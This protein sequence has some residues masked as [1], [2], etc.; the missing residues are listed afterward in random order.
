M[1][2]R[3]RYRNDIQRFVTVLMPHGAT[4]KPE[5][6]AARVRMVPTD[7]PD[8]SVCVSISK[9]DTTYLL[10]A[11]LDLEAELVYSW[12]RPMYS[13]ESGR[14]TYGD[15]ATDAFT[16]CVVET[17]AAARYSVIGAVRVEHRGKVLYE[18]LPVT[19]S[20][21]FDGGPDITGTTKMRM[22]E[23]AFKK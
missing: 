18:Q 2:I 8:K 23:G 4:E 14:S 3:D 21:R 12:R 19:S 15:Y 1:C 13:F 5:D 17:P 6:L 7:D 10:G 11:K 9:G 20:L 22:W 16:L